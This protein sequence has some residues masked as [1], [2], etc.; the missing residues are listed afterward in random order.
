M[1]E[2]LPQVSYL[3]TDPRGSVLLFDLKEFEEF[4]PLLKDLGKFS[5]NGSVVSEPPESGFD[6]DK[7][8]LGLV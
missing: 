3:P 6:L 8:I 5:L 1:F 2:P 7:I 4:V